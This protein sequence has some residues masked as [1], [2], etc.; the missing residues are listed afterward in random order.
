MIEKK[1]RVLIGKVGLDPHDRGVLILSKILTE[2]GME[3]IYMGRAQTAEAVVKAAVEEDVDVLALSDHCGVMVQIAAG[4][5]E[6]VHK[7]NAHDIPIVAGGF[8]EEKDKPI[9][10]KMGITGNFTAGTP[11]ETVVNHIRKIAGIDHEN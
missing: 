1:I 3:V 5:L 7:Y 10:E 8:I 11:H 9:L 4:V 2:A 6:Q